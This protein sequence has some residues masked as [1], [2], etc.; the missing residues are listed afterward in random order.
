MRCL[1]LRVCSSLPPAVRYL[2]PTRIIPMVA[3]TPTPMEKI[4]I[5]RF[6]T[7]NT[8][9]PPPSSLTLPKKIVSVMLLDSVLAGVVSA[10]RLGGKQVGSKL[11]Q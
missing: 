1:A 2:T 11:V 10:A 6:R 8:P 5:T 3:R 4:S 9:Q 7:L